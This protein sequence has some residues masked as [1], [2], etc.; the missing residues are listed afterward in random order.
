[1][2]IVVSVTGAVGIREIWCNLGAVFQPMYIVAIKWYM[3]EHVL[4]TVE[5]E[6]ESIHCGCQWW[7]TS[8]DLAAVDT[9]WV[10]LCCWLYLL[11]VL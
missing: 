2:A 11:Y 4:L 3:I 6:K 8:K 9:Q 1:M 7:E 5:N 10:L